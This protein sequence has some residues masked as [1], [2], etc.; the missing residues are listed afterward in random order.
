MSSSLKSKPIGFVVQ[1]TKSSKLSIYVTKRAAVGIILYILYCTF[2]N[3]LLCNP[4][5][6]CCALYIAVTNLYRL[7]IYIYIYMCV[8]VCMRVVKWYKRVHL[9][10]RLIRRSF[11]VWQESARRFSGNKILL[12]QK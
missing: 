9:K 2:K 7:Y 10:P 11:A 8:F 12:L 4:F 5:Y 3:I 6:Y 1:H